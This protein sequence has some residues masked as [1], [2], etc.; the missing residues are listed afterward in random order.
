MPIVRLTGTQIV[1]P[2][3][4]CFRQHGRERHPIAASKLFVIKTEN[5]LFATAV[6]CFI[7]WV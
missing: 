7:T 5:S 2:N 1:A 6:L 3:M 4:M